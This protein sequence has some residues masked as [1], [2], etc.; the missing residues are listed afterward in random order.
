MT[1]TRDTIIDATMA[2]IAERPFAD[3]TPGAIA[4][5]AG[6]SL[7]D[8]QR[9]FTSRMA[10][11]AA[12]SARVDQGVLGGDHSDMVD[13]SPRDRLFD[14]LMARL[15]AL[16]P[17]RAALAALIRAVR[18][19]PEL[20]LALNGIAM[21]SQAWMLAAA[22][23]S[24]RGLRGK[25]ALQSLVVGFAQVLRVFL[26]EDDP[27]LPRTMAALDKELRTLEARHNRLARIFGSALGPEA[28]PAPAPAPTP[29]QQAAP[30]APEPAPPPPAPKAAAPPPAPK[31]ATAPKPAKPAA[32]RKASGTAKPRAR[33]PRQPKTT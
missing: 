6:V 23:V 14:I 12:F 31:V 4:A 30:A 17:Y 15:D 21:R 16:S 32:R 27:G 9:H 1:D 19:D 3:V 29:P 8:L 2:L 25:L 7:A 24:P 33:K 11:L 28:T 20:A 5:E 22:G 13:E 26:S 18:R 10:I